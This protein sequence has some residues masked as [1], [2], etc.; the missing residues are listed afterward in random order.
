MADDGLQ[1]REGQLVQVGEALA[2][3]VVHRLAVHGVGQAADAAELAAAL[4]RLDELEHDL[5]AALTARHVVDVG[6]RLVR[7]ER[8][9]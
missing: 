5:L 6:E 2:Q 7:H 8:D 3:R 9:V 1:V 4:Q